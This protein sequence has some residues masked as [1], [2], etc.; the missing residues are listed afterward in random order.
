MTQ[1]GV[2]EVGTAQGRT[3]EVGTTEV[4]SYVR[5]LLSLLVPT[6]H[7]ADK[8]LELFL[9]DQSKALLRSWFFR[10][11]CNFCMACKQATIGSIGS[12]G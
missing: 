6:L 7:I 1:V 4:R 9:H 11:H 2:A 5:V 12:I 10:D 8:L 3:I